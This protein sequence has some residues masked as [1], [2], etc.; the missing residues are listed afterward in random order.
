MLES[1]TLNDDDDDNGGGIIFFK[2][3]VLFHQQ[4][5][6]KKVKKA[7]KNVLKIN[8]LKVIYFQTFFHCSLTDLI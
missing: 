5:Y 8:F 1:Q 2:N 6:D 7:L 3:L 4:I